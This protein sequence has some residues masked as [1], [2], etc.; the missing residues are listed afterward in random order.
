MA[1]AADEAVTVANDSFA[2]AKLPEALS[3]PDADLR[4][5]LELFVR[6]TRNLT[7]SPLFK[8]PSLSLE[9]T[10][11]GD[12]TFDVVCVAPVDDFGM[13]GLLT[14][15]RKL[16]QSGEPAQ[17]GRLRSDLRR[18]VERS[19][20]PASAELAGWL[21]DIGKADKAARRALPDFSVLEAEVGE[22]GV[23]RDEA[24][25]A[26]RIVD[27]WVNGEV[28]HD[29]EDKRRRI[30]WAGDPDA[31]LFGLLSGVQE[32]TKVYVLFARMAKAILEEPSLAAA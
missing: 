4:R 12:G 27:D 30:D 7:Q 14:Y 18:H 26:E 21:D 10:P 3:P 29:D 22:S 32:L 28:F 23:L 19:G 2:I 5:R 24:V 8:T 16:W 17:F 15:F 13:R 31:Y 20:L 9:C 25:R 1:A 11:R 6:T